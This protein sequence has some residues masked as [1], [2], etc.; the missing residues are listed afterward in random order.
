MPIQLIGR[1]AMLGVGLAA[2]LCSVTVAGEYKLTVD[3][4]T[5]DTG[6]FTRSGIGFNN[7]S[8][9]PVLRFKEGEDVSN[10]VTNNLS[11][12]TAVHW[13]GLILPY[14]QDGVPGISY[15]GIAP[16]ETF[17]YLLRS[18][19]A[20][21]TGFTAIQAFKSRTAPMARSLSTRKAASHS[22][23]TRNASSS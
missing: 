11:E 19:R 20:V 5:I 1:A 17:T 4:V 16:G 23:M 15:D 14:Q 8:P 18:P 6:G 2:M 21:P 3:P 9:G 22:A 12:P 7:T 13:H 10:K